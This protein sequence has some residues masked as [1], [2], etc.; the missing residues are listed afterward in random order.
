MLTRI[1]TH[2]PCMT[3][4]EQMRCDMTH[5]NSMATLKAL[6]IFVCAMKRLQI[7]MGLFC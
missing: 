6:S 2:D 1:D 4:A 5:G 7:G 3:V